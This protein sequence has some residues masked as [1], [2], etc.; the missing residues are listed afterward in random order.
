MKEE[1]K[2]WHVDGYNVTAIIEKVNSVG[3]RH[4]ATCDYGNNNNEA[5]FKLNKQNAEKIAMLPGII[6]EILEIRDRQRAG[7]DISSDLRNLFKLAEKYDSY[8]N[9]NSLI[10]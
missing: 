5:H 8:P 4:I 7:C 3:W 9:L 10:S 6:Y 2:E 1:R